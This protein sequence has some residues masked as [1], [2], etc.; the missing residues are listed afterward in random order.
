[1]EIRALIF[2]FFFLSIA[3]VSCQVNIFKP[4]FEPDSNELFSTSM[5]HEI[6]VNIDPDSLA[7]MLAPENKDS[8]YEYMVTV[9]YTNDTARYT[10]DSVGFRL[11]GN[12]SRN[13]QKKSF[14][15]SFNSF[16][17]GRKFLG[18]EKLNLNG[19]QNDPSIARS[20]ISSLLSNELGIPSMRV[21]HTLFYING[22][23]HGV[24]ANVEHIDEV[25]VQKRFGNN[26]GNLYKCLYPADLSYQGD[27]PDN[28][29][30]EV[31]A[32]RPYELKI[33]EEDD[34][35]SDLANFI[36]VLNQTSIEELPCALERVFNVDGYIRA[37]VLD[38]LI[39]NWD[40]PIYNKNNYYLYHNT[41]SGQFEYIPFDLDN[42]LGI[43]W[44]GRD[45]ASRNIYSWA[46]TNEARPIYRRILEVDEYRNRF[47]W[48]MQKYL[49]QV[50]SVTA[51]NDYMN[52][53][54]WALRPYVETDPYYSLDFGFTLND[55]DK[56]YE[57]ALNYPHTAY[58][59]RPFMEQRAS[60]AN[61]QLEE[62]QTIVPIF[63]NL[64]EQ[65]NTDEV[66][67]RV[68]ALDDKEGLSLTIEY[69]FENGTLNRIPM[70]HL[71]EG[72]YEG[73]IPYDNE[74]AVTY[75][76]KAL[77]A[78]Q[79]TRYYPRCYQNEIVLQSKVTVAINEIMASNT[80]TIQ[81]EAGDFDDWI[82]LYNY[83]DL[84]IFLGDKYLSD[85]VDNVTK[86]SF[87]DMHIMPGE[88][89][90]VWA[91]EDGNQGPLHSNFKLNK[92]GEILGI[93]DNNANNNIPI[94]ILNFD[95]LDTDQALGRIP[96]GDGVWHIVSPSPG[97]SNWV[98]S[99]E[100]VHSESI[101]LFPNPASHRINIE[102]HNI[103]TASR[104]HYQILN[105]NG[106]EI[107]KGE[108]TGNKNTIDVNHLPPGM[109]IFSLSENGKNLFKKKLVI[110]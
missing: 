75:R 58:G 5:F 28:Y 69:K 30:N 46:K 91:D 68:V 84:P 39:G 83:G 54:Q 47:T 59:I 32:R 33:N 12:T 19:Q 11:R 37:I 53:L 93:Y 81:D 63:R 64:K 14:K 76:V 86:W 66:K 34:D 45:W 20:K 67:L 60:Q 79:N 17:K 52:S 21:S 51:L 97:K 92:E 98:L 77:D 65:V 9:T 38:I 94:D 105:A 95:T 108:Y 3:T 90:L 104:M 110:L 41:E 82:E 74:E 31:F 36:R 13:A 101:K 50:Y 80:T 57:E 88:F 99:S 22:V 29:K 43:D 106:A 27:N 25:F 100:E 15:L 87:P 26:E 85:K 23:Y 24:Y 62:I 42:T 10:I 56:S 103:R 72:V 61:A 7:I 102:N 107:L 49:T 8:N 1:M 2:I 78:D 4:D 18:F 96:D 73:A 6:N 89:I 44:I 16:L 48:Y 55:Y 35:Y 71:G 70:N 40:G 109:Y